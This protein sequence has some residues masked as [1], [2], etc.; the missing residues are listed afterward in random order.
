MCSCYL[1]SDEMDFLEQWT[2]Y[3]LSNLNGAQPSVLL[4]LE[5][6]R[7]VLQSAKKDKK[8]ST[9]SSVLQ[10]R[11]MHDPCSSM[12][13]Q[14]SLESEA[15]LGPEAD[16][17]DLMEAYIPLPLKSCTEQQDD[18]VGCLTP[19][20]SERFLIQNTARIPAKFINAL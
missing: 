10:R 19:K 13:I 16:D 4:L 18:F 5:F 2:S 12:S 20:V 6:E 11:S 1:I 14:R 9:P 15:F 7:K 3:S 8:N 17:D